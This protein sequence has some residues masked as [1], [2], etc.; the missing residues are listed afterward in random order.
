MCQVSHTSKFQG[1]AIGEKWVPSGL[2]NFWLNHAHSTYH[3][4]HNYM[5]HIDKGY[6]SE[7]YVWTISSL[8]ETGVQSVK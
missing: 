1:R 6:T 4:A 5:T 7:I 3:L 8:N 2:V